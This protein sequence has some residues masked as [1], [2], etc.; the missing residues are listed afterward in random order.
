L[1]FGGTSV[2]TQIIAAVYGLAGHG[3]DNASGFYGNGSFGLEAPNP[4]LYDVTSGSN[5][6]CTGSRRFSNPSL[7]Y[8]C[9]AEPGYD[10]P[11]GMGTPRGILTPF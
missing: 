7:A 2:S 1:V 6:S 9:T 3:A 4:D 5:G 10:G 11:T 8:L